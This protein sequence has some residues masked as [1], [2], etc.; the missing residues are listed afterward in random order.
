MRFALPRFVVRAAFCA[1]ALAAAQPGAAQARPSAEPAEGVW[2]MSLDDANRMCRMTLRAEPAPGGKAF[3][4]PAG[5]RKALPI[6]IHAGAWEARPDGG[7]RLVAKDG[8]ALLDFA[9]APGGG[10][11]AVGPEGE[12]YRFVPESKGVAGAQ[13][14]QATPG[15]STPAAPRAAAAA[16]AA[17]NA[18][19]ASLAGRYA[20]LREEGKDTGC[21][22]TLEDRPGRGPKG[23]LRAFL[24]PACRD[25]GIVIFDPIG[26]SFA[27]GKLTLYAR[28]G[29]GAAFLSNPDGSWTKEPGG[30]ALGL[31]RI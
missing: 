10:L 22:V 6:L 5:C 27:G 2:A 23:S 29:H 4:A 14:A 13:F 24:A 30:K 25:Q 3:A 21:M 15:F 17:T 31:K 11:S 7:V 16:P 12:S 19:R 18:S 20:V 8:G 28:K 26:W 9:P 1:F